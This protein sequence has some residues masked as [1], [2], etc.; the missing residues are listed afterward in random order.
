MMKV[1]PK[2]INHYCNSCTYNT[3]MSQQQTAWEHA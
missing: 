2:L 3:M 1:T